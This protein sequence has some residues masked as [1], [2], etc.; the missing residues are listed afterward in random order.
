MHESV[1]NRAA[2][3]MK[4]DRGAAVIVD[5]SRIAPLGPLARLNIQ[6]VLCRETASTLNRG[7]FFCFLIEDAD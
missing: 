2:H 6:F 7:S 3:Y 1:L 5:L 4:I